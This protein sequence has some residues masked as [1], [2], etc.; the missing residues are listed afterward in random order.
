LVQGAGISSNFVNPDGEY[1]DASQDFIGQG[2]ANVVAG[3][4]QGMPVGGSMSASSLVKEAGAK[5]RT[6][7]LI[8]GVVMGIVILAFGSVVGYIA[9]P[10]LAGLLMTVGYGTIK[11]RDIKEVWRTGKAQ[12]MV[13]AVTFALTMLIAL[14]YAVLVGVGISM[15]LY[16]IKQSNRITIKQRIIDN[17]G[18]TREIDAPEEVPADAVIMLQPYGSLFFASA[19]IFEEALPNVTPETTNSVVILRLRGRDDLG[20][21]FTDVLL[22]YSEALQDADSKLVIVTSSPNVSEQLAVARVTDAVGEKNIYA[23]SKWVGET[24]GQAYDDAKAWIEARAQVSEKD[25]D[26]DHPREGEPDD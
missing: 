19:P 21:T 3:L 14:Q 6:A 12:A 15:I 11:P 13:M 7:L 1:P 22:R 23:S 16:I 4:F 26:S 8:A 9:M 24:A 25:P 17:S 2:A 5:S 18:D 10:A 20:S